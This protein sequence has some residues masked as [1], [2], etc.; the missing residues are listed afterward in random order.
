MKKYDVVI[1]GASA[2]GA[3]AASTARKFYPDKS[4]CVIREFEQVPIPCGIPYIYGTI[5]DPMKNLIP[6]GTMFP[7]QK[8]DSV[9][10]IAES[11]DLEKKV[12]HG[13]NEDISYDRL[14]LATGSL[15]IEP[16][17]KG[18]TLHNVFA[19]HK[20]T[21]YLTKL[22]EQVK[23]SQK[24]VII[25][26]GFIG[27]E[28]A[29]ELKKN[30]PE[31]EVTIIEMQD[32]CL[33]L[34][35]DKDFCDLAEKELIE[36]GIRILTQSRV[37]EIK[38]KEKVEGILLDN[39][40]VIPADLVILGIG[41]KANNQLGKLANLKIG[42]TGGI[43]VD[44]YMQTSDPFVFACGDCA[45]KTSFFDKTPSSLRLASIATMEARVAGSNLFMQHRMNHGVVGCFSTALHGKAFASA[46]LTSD[47]AVRKG[48][49]IVIG[50]AE[51]VNRHPGL[52]PG[53]ALMK[54]RLIFEKSEGIIVG[55]QIFGALS[56]GELINAISAFI[57]KKMTAD[58]IALFQAGTHPALTASPIAYQLVN[59]AESASVK[60]R[61]FAR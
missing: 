25:G 24:I 61:S 59:A 47:E 44:F 52:M 22:M 21:P 18:A 3:V 7:N 57:S 34:V 28:M 45:E 31:H 56:G 58:D 33:N 12:V 29:E 15:P 41:C 16:P 35:Y 19:I 30:N 49:Q 40:D 23:V 46:G 54:V 10:V 60:L 14:I 4:I 36:Q 39:G 37:M 50:D 32:R 1:I 27:V 6:V 42:P 48:Y 17:I 55:G 38:G 8:I 11:I 5:G 53:S 20:N 26:G 2:A 13:K 43:V 51:S 9:I